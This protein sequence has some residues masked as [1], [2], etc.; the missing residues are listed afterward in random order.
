MNNK[1]I[2]GSQLYGLT[3]PKSD[4]DYLVISEE[5]I[6]DKLD[7]D[8]EV[9][10]LQEFKD[11]L[12]L[13]DLKCLEVYFNYYKEVLKLIPEL[14]FNKGFKINKSQLRRA[15]SSVAS[16]SNVKAKKKIA[17]GDVYIGRKSFFHSYRILYMYTQLINIDNSIKGFLDYR[18]EAVQAHLRP[19]YNDIVLSPYD[20][21]TTLY[22]RL[23][24]TYDVPMRQLIHTLR[25]SC[26]LDKDKN[27]EYNNV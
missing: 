3:N 11:K 13:H 17:Q 22:A 10:S 15:I 2:V 4:T 21:T 25:I 9:L 26:P 23:K 18:L 7:V 27:K 5:E 14:E 19:I 24:A 20:D 8:V 12:Q 1:F 6:Q 16:N